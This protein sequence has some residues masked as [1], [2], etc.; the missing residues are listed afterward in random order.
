MSNMQDFVA[1]TSVR[2]DWM[3]EL[4]FV[5]KNYVVINHENATAKKKNKN[6]NS[7]PTHDVA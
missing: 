4:L 1:L 2:N 5:F 6:N 7:I 3:A